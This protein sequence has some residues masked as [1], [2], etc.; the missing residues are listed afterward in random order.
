MSRTS[1]AVMT[2][3][4]AL[5][6]VIGASAQAKGPESAT[7]SG[8]GIDQPI[9]LIS[10]SKSFDTYENDAPVTLIGLTGLWLG[11]L[12]VATAPPEN[13]GPAYT[14]TWAN[15]GPPG[16]PIESR[17]IH[18]YVYV[19]AP[20]VPLI[21]TPEQIGLDGWGTEVIGWFEAPEEIAPTINEVIAW[22]TSD[23]AAALQ[24]V[25]L[26]PVTE[27]QS[28]TPTAPT[29]KGAL[30]PIWFGIAALVGIGGFASWRV[31]R[32]A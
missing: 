12:P 1:G 28:H 27:P 30:P 17:T 16:E 23:E 9:E 32:H 25:T 5:V 14:L 7:L 10:V 21:H 8:P 2:L 31:R 6:V 18:Q 26:Q 4:L 24:P 20:G 3:A 29:S 19:D 15:M 13:P 22:S 11:S